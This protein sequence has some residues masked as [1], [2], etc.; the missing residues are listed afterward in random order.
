MVHLLRKRI[1]IFK[2]E[3]N[4]PE[5]NIAKN[6]FDRLDREVP[7]DIS[8][9][10]SSSNKLTIDQYYKT[11]L[12]HCKTQ[13]FDLPYLDD[14]ILLN[15]YMKFKSISMIAETLKVLRIN[16]D[17]NEELVSVTLNAQ[18]N[19]IFSERNFIIKLK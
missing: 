4:I 7:N 6:I 19:P 10:E 9:L 11:C 15:E 13:V 14:K 18:I 8:Q 5:Q 1:S 3:T 2:E 17:Y 12:L 16:L